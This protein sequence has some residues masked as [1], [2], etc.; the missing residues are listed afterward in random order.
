M[1]LH[2]RPEMVSVFNELETS[3][4][5]IAKQHS[6]AYWSVGIGAACLL[7][8][9]V[10]G[11]LGIGFFIFIVGLVTGFVLF[12][13]VSKKADVY[14]L[15]FK[16]KII[17]AGLR[18]LNENLQ[19]NPL[20]GI[21]EGDFINSCLFSQTPDRYKTE[22]LVYGKIDKT[23]IH[24]AE[25]HA[26]YKTETQTKNGKQTHW[27]DIFK[28]IIFCAD[29]NKNFNGLTVVRPKGFG[30]AFGKW[31]SQ[32][33]MGNKRIVELENVNFDKMFITE[34]GDQVEARYILTPSLMEKLL[35]LN[36]YANS[37]IS[38]SFIWSSVYIAFPLNHNYFEAP[39][40]KSLL[41][42]E[43]LEKDLNM[44]QLMLH[45]VEELD[46]NTRIWTKQ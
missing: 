30:G 22:D 18:Q 26:E 37:T 8:G 2:S 16:Y 21:S 19:I 17:G 44:L 32:N 39:V 27:H 36:Q 13:R 14:K 31:L 23:Q 46:L 6:R 3:R 35:E 45:V 12:F 42:A 38:V 40:F 15:D 28:G 24:F 33:V 9:F 7:A 10:F 29:F 5:Y 1:Q 20:S 4:L 34:S 11:L 43:V 25:V 41:N